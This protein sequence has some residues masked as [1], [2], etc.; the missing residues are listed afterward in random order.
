MQLFNTLL[1]IYKI[2]DPWWNLQDYFSNGSVVSFPSSIHLWPVAKSY[3]HRQ[4]ISLQVWYMVVAVCL[5]DCFIQLL[6]LPV[7]L[8][9]I[10]PNSM[11]KSS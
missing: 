3:Q 8:R 4:T 6:W 2:S 11:I 10:W 7:I 5:D 1:D 9:A